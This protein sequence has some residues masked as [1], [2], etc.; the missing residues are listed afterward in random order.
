MWFTL[1]KDALFATIPAPPTNAV[2]MISD[3]AQVI[4]IRMV[5]SRLLLDG[6]NGPEGPPIVIRP[7]GA[8]IYC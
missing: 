8:N 4:Q 3:I 5:I 1:F 2:A 7:C 6:I